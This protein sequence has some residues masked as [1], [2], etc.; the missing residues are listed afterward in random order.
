MVSW[1]LI[2]SYLSDKKKQILIMGSLVGLLSF[3]F[4][5]MM[6]SFNM[7][8][9]QAILA[10]YPEGA[11]DFFGDI[12]FMANPYGFVCMEFFLMYWLY[13]GIYVVWVAAG[14]ITTEIED[15]TMEIA[16]TKPI[17]RNEFLGNKI[18]YFYA[19]L[20]GLT[21]VIFGIFMLAT[22]T[23]PSII[24]FGLW[25]NRLWASYI[26]CA[27]YIGF[28]ASV[29]IFISTLSLKTK[30]ALM[31]GIIVL[32]VMY[33]MNGIASYV[34]QINFLAYFTVFRYFNPAEYI[35]NGN[36]VLFYRDLIVLLIGNAVFVIGSFLVFNKKDIPI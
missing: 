23:S 14:I 32:F 28:L 20:F 22:L 5:Q 36:Y 19:F 31:G 29:T 24:E 26:N 1:H 34:D 27:L 11:M 33:F 21:A 13:S 4:I 7:G 8:D 3:A 15:K 35:V 16:L 6:E 12:S 25:W 18:I 2:K 10:V 30:K 17:N 9:L